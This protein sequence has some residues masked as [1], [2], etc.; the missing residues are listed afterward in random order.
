MNKI[1]HPLSTFYR[2]QAAPLTGVMLTF[3]LFGCGTQP[4]PQAVE[5]IAQ[6]TSSAQESAQKPERDLSFND[7]TLE[8][9]DQQGRQMWKVKAKEATYSKDQKTAQLQSPIGQL[10]QDGKPVYNITAQTGE[11]EKDGEKLFL[12]GQ[13]VAKAPLHNLVLRGNELEWRPK[14]DLLIVR[15]QL[16]GSHPQL[17]AVA[18]EARVKSRAALVELQGKV[19]AIAKDPTVQ[20]RTEHLI[21]QMREQK[22]IGDRP[23][24]IDRYEGKKNTDRGTANSGEVN[25]KTKVTT[26]RQDAQISLLKPPMQV[27]GNSLSWN[28]NTKIVSADQPVRIVNTQQ[29][30]VV[31]ANQGRMDLQKEIAYLSGDVNGVGLNRQS[32]KANSLTW[33]L[34]NQ[35][36]E[37]NGDV[38]YRQVDPPA[39]FSGQ[40]AVGKLQEQNIEVSGGNVVTEIVPQQ[41]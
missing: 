9:A 34:P 33:Y 27:T 20:M 7:V 4:Q 35:L 13:I 30:M 32:L 5:K 29:Q 40:K 8:Q 39:S 28:M 22:L 23:L 2:C 41:K 18:Q 19:Q 12:K 14:E 25:L 21:W 17:Q 16:T 10:F 15:N 36:M 24:Q 3:T 11:I 1:F 6:D 26:L 38:V 37:A 31:T